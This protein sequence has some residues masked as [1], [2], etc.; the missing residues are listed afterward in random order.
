MPG[1]REPFILFRGLTKGPAATWRCPC[2]RVSLTSFPC[3]ASEQISVSFDYCWSQASTLPGEQQ[4][5]EPKCAEGKGM[6]QA[7]SC[8]EQPPRLPPSALTKPTREPSA[9]SCHHWEG[10]R[11]LLSLGSCL[12]AHFL[13]VHRACS[14]LCGNIL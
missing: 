14:A 6:S 13:S 4:G 11:S 3:L 8:A 2:L 12:S 1:K 5:E 7:F 10:L 9:C